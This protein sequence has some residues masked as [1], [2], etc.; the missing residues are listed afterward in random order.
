[1]AR[2]TERN[3]GLVSSEYRDMMDVFISGNS[4][5]AFGCF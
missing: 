2:T 1:M 4:V 5:A 3:G